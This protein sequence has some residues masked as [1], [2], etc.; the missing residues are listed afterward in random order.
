MENIGTRISKTKFKQG[1]ASICNALG[2]SF[3]PFGM[4]QSYEGSVIN[5]PNLPTYGE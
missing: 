1:N 5:C 4:E 2:L 3:F